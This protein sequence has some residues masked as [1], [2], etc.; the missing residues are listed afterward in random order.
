MVWD[1]EP[2][3]RNSPERSFGAIIALMENPE[4][5]PLFLK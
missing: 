1:F 4:F 3:I 2:G 5:G